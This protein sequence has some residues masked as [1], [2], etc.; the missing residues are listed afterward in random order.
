MGFPVNLEA[1]MIK[2]TKRSGRSSNP[3]KTLPNLDLTKGR[4]GAV[5]KPKG[6][7]DVKSLCLKWQEPSGIRGEEGGEKIRCWS[8]RWSISLPPM[9]AGF[10]CTTFPPLQVHI[11]LLRYS[12]YTEVG[13]PDVHSKISVFQQVQNNPKIT[14]NQLSIHLFMA[15][16]VNL[17]TH[18]TKQVFLSE[19]GDHLKR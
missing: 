14:S 4:G 6:H 9:W 8:S 19:I 11:P 5:R 13:S 3:F 2:E 10:W 12:T 15:E 7:H 18:V 1:Y 17:V 16:F